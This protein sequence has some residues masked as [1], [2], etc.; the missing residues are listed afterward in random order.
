LNNNKI[1]F[2]FPGQGSQAVGMGKYLYDNYP[3]ARK[4]FAEADATLNYSLSHL[5]F[6]GPDEE[7]RQTVNVQP[8]I[9]TVSIACLRVAQSIG[10]QLFPSPNFT[11]GHSLGEYSALVTSG[12]LS[13]HDALVL[14]QS[15]GRL[16][17][18]AAEKN[19]GGM[20]AIVGS[21]LE[22]VQNICSATNTEISN[23]NS[24][25]QIIISG[26]NADLDKAKITAQEMGARRI[27]S[28][29]VSGAFHSRLMLEAAAGLKDEISQIKLY[30]PFIPTI[31]NVSAQELM[32]SNAIEGELIDQVVKCVQWQKSIEY[33][34]DNGVRIFIEIGHGQILSGLVKRINH[35]VDIFN[36]DDIEVEQQVQN[37][38]NHHLK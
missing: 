17:Q 3:I 35:E 16:M 26:T 19:P 25:G 22:I 20:L 21:S 9:L 14:T 12:A 7:L 29:K 8:A 15:R 34:V 4:T 30:V 1:A 18:K 37:L 38:I 6:E 33:M 5:C 2:L 31:S 36:I 28:L 13:F 10:G 11:A 23:I 32:N 27:M 24:P